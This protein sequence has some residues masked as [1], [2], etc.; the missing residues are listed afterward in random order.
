MPSAPLVEAAPSIEG[1]EPADDEVVAEG[2]RAGSRDCRRGARRRTD[3]LIR[4][5]SLTSGRPDGKIRAPHIQTELNQFNPGPPRRRG[6]LL[7]FGIPIGAPVKP[8]AFG[9]GLMAFALK[10]ASG[11]VSIAADPSR[12]NP[13]REPAVNPVPALFSFRLLRRLPFLAG[14]AMIRPWLPGNPGPATRSAPEGA[15]NTDEG[16]TRNLLKKGIGL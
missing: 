5:K 7:R 8:D 4:P 1:P 3:G 14:P 2:R 11:W 13:G 6:G 16:L 9:F 10:A 15:G 12:S